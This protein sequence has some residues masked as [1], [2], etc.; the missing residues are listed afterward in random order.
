MAIFVPPEIAAKGAILQ[1]TGLLKTFPISLNCVI[2]SGCCSTSFCFSGKSPQTIIAEKTVMM[3]SMAK[4]P[5]QSENES[6]LCKGV[7]APS[8]PNP[9]A[10][11]CKPLIIGKRSLGNQIT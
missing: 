9:P 3:A 4:I 2:S 1:N 5:R 8:A 11:I 10:T 6:A 7:V